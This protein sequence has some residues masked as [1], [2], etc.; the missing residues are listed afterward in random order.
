M[1]KIFL[2][3]LAAACMATSCNEDLLNTSPTTAVS[4][5]TLLETTEG[6]LMALNGSIRWFWQWGMSVT[7]NAHQVIGPQGYALMGDLMGEDMVMAGPGN[8]WFWYDYLYDV[9]DGYTSGAWRSYDCWNFYYTLICQVNYIINAKDTMTGPKEDVDYIVGNAYAFRAYAYHYL[10][11]I[12]ARSYIGHENMLGVPVYTEPTTSKTTGKARSTNKEVYTQITSDLSTA[13]TLLE[14]KNRKHCSHID[15]YVANGILARVALYMGDW[16]TAYTAAEN[17]TKGSKALT[18]DVKYGYN[19]A[20]A[21]DVLW[22]A[23]IIRDQGTTNPQFLAHMDIAFDGYGEDARKCCSEWLYNKITVGDSRQGWWNYEDLNSG[24]Y[25]KKGYQQYKFRFVD[26]SDPYV[27]ADHI[28][29]RV[30]EMYLTMAEAKCRL[31]DFSSAQTI[32]ND[33]MNGYRM[34]EGFSYSCS[35]KTGNELGAL[36]TDET[37]SLLEE[38]ILQRR[39]E[40]WGEFGRI[41]DIKRLRQG[42]VR[43]V[44]MGHPAQALCATLKLSDPESFDWVLTIPQA[45]LDANDLMVQNPMGSEATATNGDDPALSTAVTEPAE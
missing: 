30:P 1:K 39:I 13:I 36:T 25:T 44:E 38:I 11:M 10:E 20:N 32:L 17:A 37:G 9:K 16:E 23:E 19:N 2:S 45:E 22:G 24:G 14:G 18:K 40:L 27:G 6:G 43:T 29:M 3:I 4:G 35:D 7:G 41:F 31:S 28:F 8:G 5:D 33:F 34:G 15:Y 42:F 26:A 21:T 12:F